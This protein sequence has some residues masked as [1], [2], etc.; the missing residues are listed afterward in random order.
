M[1]A[2]DN[3]MHLFL[4]IYFV[5]FTD[6]PQDASPAL[7]E[8]AIVRRERFGIAT[9]WLDLPVCNAYTDSLR[10]VGATIHHRSR[11]MNGVTCEMDSTTAAMVAAWPFV[12]GVECTRDNSNAFVQHK[13]KQLPPHEPEPQW[14]SRS[15][16]YNQLA[17]FNLHPLHRVGWFGQG[18]TMAICDGGFLS[19]NEMDCFDQSNLLGWYDFTD[20]LRFAHDGRTAEEDFFGESGEHGSACLS[21]IAALTDTYEGAAP[22][23]QYYLMRSEEKV[24]E[25]PKEMDNLVA[26]LECADSLGVDIFSV[27]LGYAY[28]DNDAWTLPKSALNGTTTRCSRAALIAARKGMLVV[29]AAGNDGNNTWQTI[30]APADADS[31]LTVGAVDTL[32]SIA[33]FSSYGMTADGRIKPDVCA[34]GKRAALIS[35]WSGGVYYSN[36]TS[37]ATP[38]LAGM[39]ACLWSALPYEDAMSIRRRIIA[40]ADR[41]TQPVE[42]YGYG[43]PDAYAAYSGI[44]AIPTADQSSCPVKTIRNGQVVICRDGIYYNLLGTKVT[45]D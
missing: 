35:P 9:D 6:K 41:S 21:A 29:V 14:E 36:G 8:A 42:H 38:L 39:A 30:A 16:T 22:A 7:S 37:F 43:I 28:F 45:N 11:W 2:A 44:T 15:S 23:V 20:D 32:R 26:A 12:T 34:V 27:S 19:A 13:R 17:V 3:D 5:L 33:D 1:L 40:S 10:Q 31:I 18:I 25:S 24:T 4:L